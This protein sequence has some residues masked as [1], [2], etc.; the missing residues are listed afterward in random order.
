ML[1]HL[2]LEDTGVPNTVIM[3]LIQDGEGVTTFRTIKDDK[4]FQRV[5]AYVRELTNPNLAEGYDRGDP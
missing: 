3:Q 1:L 5:V 4:E 2:H